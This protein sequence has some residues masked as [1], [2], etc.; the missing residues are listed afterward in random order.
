MLV[1]YGGRVMEYGGMEDV[2]KNPT[3]PYTMGLLHAIPRIDQQGDELSTIPGN[4][5]NMLHP[6][7]G[8]PFQ[9]RCDFAEDICAT[10]IPPL[11]EWQPHRSRA[12]HR[13]IEALK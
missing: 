11:T 6:P 3:H 10:T 5:P 9:P 7:A 4:P 13:P 12:C 2:F 8:C 1:M